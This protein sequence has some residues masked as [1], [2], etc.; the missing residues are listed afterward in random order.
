MPQ[1]PYTELSTDP[2]TASGLTAAQIAEAQ[3]R[4]QAGKREFLR[5]TP[6]LR[7]RLVNDRPVYEATGDPTA[8]LNAMNRRMPLIP[9][10]VASGPVFEVT[11]VSTEATPRVVTGRL[12]SSVSATLSATGA[13]RPSGTRPS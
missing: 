9:F 2:G 11:D 4:M 12:R 6:N 10:R 3:R 1:W 8:F 7:M 13:L 5:L